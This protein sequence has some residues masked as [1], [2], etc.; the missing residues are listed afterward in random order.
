MTINNFKFL[1]FFIINFF[2]IIDCFNVF[3]N[4]KVITLIQYL[5]FLYRIFSFEL[6]SLVIKIALLV[7][8]AVL[9]DIIIPTDGLIEDKVELVFVE[10]PP[11]KISVIFNITFF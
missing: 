1:C 9:D 11:I 7:N 4:N 3:S 10:P 5:N 2:S 8:K 6:Y